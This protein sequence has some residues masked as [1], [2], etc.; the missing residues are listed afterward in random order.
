M[1]RRKPPRRNYRP[2]AVV[3]SHAQLIELAE[4]ALKEFERKLPFGVRLVIAVAS[5]EYAG[6]ASNTSPPDVASILQSS[7]LAQQGVHSVR[8]VEI[9]DTHGEVKEEK[10]GKSR[11]PLK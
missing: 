4:K 10:H 6:V 9:I 3:L 7:L 5:G 11:R 1:A 8:G 2:I